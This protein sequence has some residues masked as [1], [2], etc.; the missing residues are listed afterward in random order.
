MGDHGRS[1][2]IVGDGAARLP[3]AV[4]V[5][6]RE[7]LGVVRRL[8]R[9]EARVSAELA[10]SPL[11]DGRDLVA[12][13][14]GEVNGRSQRRSRGI[15]KEVKAGQGKSSQVKGQGR[16]GIAY[17]ERQWRGGSGSLNLIDGK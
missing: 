8:A 14:R 5:D 3:P 1:W 17:T 11:G 15:S 7:P 12:A 4:G 2:E 16:S 13:R 6:A 10:A 9:R